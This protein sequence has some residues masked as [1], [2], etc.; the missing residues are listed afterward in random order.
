MKANRPAAARR[1]TTA[2]PE[3]PARSTRPKPRSPTASGDRSFMPGSPR[4]GSRA[5]LSPARSTR[6][7]P[8]IPTSPR[9]LNLRGRICQLRLPNPPLARW[10]VRG[11][12]RV[13]LNALGFRTFGSE[14]AAMLI[15]PAD[16][17]PA[18]PAVSTPLAYSGEHAARGYAPTRASRDN[19]RPVAGDDWP[20]YSGSGTRY[21]DAWRSS[22]VAIFVRLGPQRQP[23]VPQSLVA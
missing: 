20:G 7:K 3:P 8:P 13:F 14:G 19:T 1:A 9:P 5:Y 22:T 12:S 23:P 2:A 17:H 6:P 4:C 10:G 16:E 21:T 11:Q 15:R 18:T